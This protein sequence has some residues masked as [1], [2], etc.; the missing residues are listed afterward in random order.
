MP[1]VPRLYVCHVRVLT[2][3]WISSLSN[4]RDDHETT[5]EFEAKKITDRFLCMRSLVFG[6]HGAPVGGRFREDGRRTGWLA[7]N[8][9]LAGA[10][11]HRAGAGRRVDGSAAFEFARDMDGHDL[12]RADRRFVRFVNYCRIIYEK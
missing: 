6:H 11:N 8:R 12:E 3:R 7:L 1:L 5:A 4:V 2:A 10:R 9:F